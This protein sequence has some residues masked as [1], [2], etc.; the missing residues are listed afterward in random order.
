[1]TIVFVTHDIG[2]AYY[3][4]DAIYIMHEGRIVEQG[5]PDQV[6]QAPA[7]AITRQLLD[8]IPQVNRDWIERGATDVA[9]DA[10]RKLA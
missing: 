4:S 10:M 7:S 6:T 8:D 2:L 9:A 3:V 1:M 5:A